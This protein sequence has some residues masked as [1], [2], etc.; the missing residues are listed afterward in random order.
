MYCECASDWQWMIAFYIFVLQMA[1]Y[2]MTLELNVEDWQH[3]Y[4]AQIVVSICH[5]LS[6]MP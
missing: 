6:N 3:V 4:P 1:S 2:I 5:L